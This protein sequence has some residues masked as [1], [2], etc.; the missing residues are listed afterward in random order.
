MQNRHGWKVNP[1]SI[2]FSPGVVTALSMA[3]QAFTEP[4]DQVVVQPPVYTPFYHMVEKNGRHILHNPLL[5]KDGAYAMDFEDL[6]T[7]LRDPS[8]TLFILCNPH[9][10]SGRSWAGKIY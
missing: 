1:E 10:P 9:N 4:G 3:V 2:T 5:E 8:V 7:K 6:E